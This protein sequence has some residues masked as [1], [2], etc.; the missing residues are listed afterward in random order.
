MP[1]PA[2]EKDR[3]SLAF[4][5]PCLP[6][7]LRVGMSSGYT[8]GPGLSRMSGASRPVSDASGR[9]PHGASVWR[10][11]VVSSGRVCRY[12]A[13]CW[14]GSSLQ[15]S[16][17]V[18]KQLPCSHPPCPPMLLRLRRLCTPAVLISLRAE[19]VRFRRLRNA[20]LLISVRPRLL[21]LRVLRHIAARHHK[22]KRGGR[23]RRL[24]LRW[25][26]QCSATR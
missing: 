9:F 2:P 6:S 21:R 24:R 13:S 18:S 8:S 23:R 14:L 5:C 7:A 10:C 20:A 19:L 22:R 16:H 15:V 1:Q 25:D 26:S 17:K 12:R 3:P 4:V 11:R